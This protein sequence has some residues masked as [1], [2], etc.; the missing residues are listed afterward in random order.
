MTTGTTTGLSCFMMC[1]VPLLPGTKG[2]VVPCG[3]VMTHPTDIAFLMLSRSRVS[4]FLLTSFHA[5][6]HV[7][8]ILTEPESAKTRGSKPERIVSFAAI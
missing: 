6:L 4:T 7:R 1:A 2:F 5:S 3:K 8:F